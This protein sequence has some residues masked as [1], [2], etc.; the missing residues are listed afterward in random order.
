EAMELAN[1]MPTPP[2][3]YGFSGRRRIRR[4]FMH[5]INA[6]AA[7]MN[8]TVLQASLPSLPQNATGAA[9]FGTWGGYESF[10]LFSQYRT[11][12]Y[13]PTRFDTLEA[14]YPPPPNHRGRFLDQPTSFPHRR[15]VP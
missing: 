10:R 8:A 1:S 11:H 3:A 4:D 13:K 9:G 14:A 12:L 15:S 6:G 7:V 5:R 2:A